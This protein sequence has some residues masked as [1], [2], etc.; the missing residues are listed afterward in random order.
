MQG[1]GKDRFNERSGDRTVRRCLILA[2]ATFASAIVALSGSAAEA[3]ADPSSGTRPDVNVV[4]MGDSYTAGTGALWGRKPCYQTSF[5][6]AGVY[7]RAISSRG[8]LDNSLACNGWKIENVPGPFKEFARKRDADVAFISIGG[9]DLDFGKA[10]LNCLSPFR[11]GDR[12]RES[13]LA[14]QGLIRSDDETSNV[15]KRTAALLESLL[16]PKDGFSKARVVLVGYPLLVADLPNRI[17]FDCET[18]GRPLIQWAPDLKWFEFH[19]RSWFDPNAEVRRI[20]REFETEQ[21]AMVSELQK[22]YGNRIMFVSRQKLFEGHEAGSPPKVNWLRDVRLAA[23]PTPEEVSKIERFMRENDL[24]NAISTMSAFVDPMTLSFHPN[25]VGWTQTGKYLAR[26]GVERA[27][28]PRNLGGADVSRYCASMG[29]DGVAVLTKPDAFGWRCE[30][31]S[32]YKPARELHSIDMAEVCLGQQG[33]ESIAV[34]GGGARDWRCRTSLGGVDL[35]KWC[36]KRGREGA[37][38]L[39]D[40]TSSGWRCEVTTSE[41]A[42]RERAGIDLNAACRR[43]YAGDAFAVANNSA[44]ASSWSCRGD[45]GGVDLAA[46][47]ATVGNSGTAVLEGSDAFSWRCEVTTGMRR[48][49]HQDGTDLNRACAEQYGGG[50]SAGLRNERDAFSWY[51]QSNGNNLGGVDIQAYC[52]R[53]RSDALYLNRRDAFSWRCRWY[54]D[55]PLRKRVNVDMNRACRA[56]KAV[57]AIAV[58]SDLSSYT[59]WGCQR[60]FGRIDINSYCASIGSA[61]KA[62]LVSNDASGWRCERTVGTEPVRSRRDINMTAVCRDQYQHGAT[63]VAGAGARDWSCRSESGLDLSKWCATQRV[64]GKS[65]LVENSPWGWRCSSMSGT[66]PVRSRNAIGMQ[67][68][69]GFSHP[70]EPAVRA[71]LANASDPGGWE[72]WA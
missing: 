62:V 49:E 19:C 40:T 47:C 50:T 23:T 41:K 22:R 30:V 70:A 69:C 33:G 44:A 37:A 39:V 14:A 18:T 31:T 65:V 3:S 29:A 52:A 67:L 45:L 71:V 32:G 36:A 17:S 4:A 11:N 61:G 10:A 60:K 54:E 68:A 43:Q 12:C 42:V 26:L 53:L 35:A 63:A 38:V 5:N 64:G 34:A 57:D 51:C 21:I 16:D 6:Y 28:A 58:A 56:Q 46:Y 59:S 25:E 15:V 20:G 66:A 8:W 27:D 1:A 48:I 9:N 55:Q 72:C 2:L 7:Q 13:L 24:P